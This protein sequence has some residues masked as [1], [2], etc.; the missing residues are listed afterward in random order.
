MERARILIFFI[1]HSDDI[2]HCAVKN[3]FV[4]WHKNVIVL[5]FLSEQFAI[6]MVDTINQP[7]EAT[8][9]L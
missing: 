2:R 9:C 5:D 3:P 8:Q 6:S 4:S 1:A 7:Q